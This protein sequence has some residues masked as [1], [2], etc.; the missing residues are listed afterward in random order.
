MKD[1]ATAT[2]AKKKIASIWKDGMFDGF[3]GWLTL[4]V[5]L[6][7]AL[8][9]KNYP[10]FATWMCDYV[11]SPGVLVVVARDFYKAVAQVGTAKTLA[12]YA[13]IF[14]LA[15]AG[16]VYRILTTPMDWVDGV[17]YSAAAAT[18]VFLLVVLLHRIPQKKGRKKD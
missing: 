9:C 17:L 13:V 16:V 5:C 11:V 3:L 2:Q 12:A 1:E 14:F 15:L 4:M 8:S 7:T 6:I 18:T 10:A